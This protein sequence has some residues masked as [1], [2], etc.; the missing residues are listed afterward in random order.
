[1]FGLCYIQDLE[2]NCS[3]YGGRTFVNFI[4]FVR[5]DVATVVSHANVVLLNRKLM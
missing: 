2:Q 1:M 5:E 3:V 4:E